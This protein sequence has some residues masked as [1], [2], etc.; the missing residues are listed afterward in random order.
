MGKFIRQVPLVVMI[1]LAAS[2]V[3]AFVFLPAHMADMVTFMQRFRKKDLTKTKRQAYFKKVVNSY[4]G[5]LQK[6]IARRDGS[7]AGIHG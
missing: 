4:T 2:L 3:E 5:V 6:A 7:L 1:A